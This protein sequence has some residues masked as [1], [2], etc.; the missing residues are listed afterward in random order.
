METNFKIAIPKPCHEDWNAMTPDETGRFCN[1]CTKGVVDFTNMKAVEIQDYFIK[2]QGQRICGRFKNEQVKDKFDLQIPQSVLN[3]RMSF[4][5]AFLLTLFMVMGSTLFSCKNHNDATLGEVSVVNDTVENR[6]TKGMILP[7]KDSI[8]EEQM[9]LG[10]IDIKRYD[11]LV[12]AGVKMPPLPPPPKV[13][14]V[15]FIKVKAERKEIITGD[16]TVINNNQSQIIEEEF[17]TGMPGITVYP[18]YIGGTKKFYDF[19]KENYKFPKKANKINGELRASFVIEKDGRINEVEVIKDLGNGAGAE[20]I[21]VL[22]KSAKWY[23]AEY[24]GKK[25]RVYF[26]LPLLI[27][28]DTVSRL[29][30]KKITAKIDAIELIRITKFDN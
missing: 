2:N 18:D 26:E 29:F 20:L 3:Q 27:T 28:N 17:I 10:K 22:N 19:I 1:V 30:D 13:K 21:K 9:T 25:Q 14:Q 23:P 6:T 8:N 7:P 5:K 4:H 16:V 15:K 11:S 24:N 12:K